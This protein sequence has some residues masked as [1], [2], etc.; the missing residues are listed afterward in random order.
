MDPELPPS[1]ELASPVDGSQPAEI[2]PSEEPIASGTLPPPQPRWPDKPWLKIWTEPRGTI[3]AIVDTDPTR[4]VLLLAVIGG[5]A[6][7]L[8]RAS[9]Q[10]LGDTWPVVGIVLLALLLGSIGGI[11]SLYISGAIFRWTGSLLGGQA[12]SEQVRSALAIPLLVLVGLGFGCGLALVM[13]G[14]GM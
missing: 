11:L 2:T 1:T 7:S 4:Y 8:N 9:T 13:S 12:S 10:D 5:I 14:G 3:R 6:E